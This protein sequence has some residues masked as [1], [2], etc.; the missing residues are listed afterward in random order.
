[1]RNIKWKSTWYF[2]HQNHNVLIFN[3][4]CQQFLSLRFC[5]YLMNYEGIRAYWTY[6][7]K[8][9]MKVIRQVW[10][11]YCKPI[12]YINQII[13]WSWIMALW[14][15]CIIYSAQVTGRTFSYIIFGS[16]GPLVWVDQILRH[17][18][19]WMLTPP[20]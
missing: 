19:T 4:R 10:W 18:S 1:M 7:V 14:H 9:Y 20:S 11:E 12:A 15:T 3:L 5:Q 13:A 8:D 17:R 6:R 16:A 2:T